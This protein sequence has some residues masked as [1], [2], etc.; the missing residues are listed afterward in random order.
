MNPG[1]NGAPVGSGSGVAPT[2][3]RRAL[4]ARVHQE[5]RIARGRPHDPFVR[6]TATAAVAD[7]LDDRGQRALCAPAGRCSQP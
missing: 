3:Q 4:A 2:D 7:E 5:V 6:Q 1:W